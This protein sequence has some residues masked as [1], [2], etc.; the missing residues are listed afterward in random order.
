MLANF[1]THTIFCDGNN[2]PEE[3]V[4]AA[5]EKDFSAIGFS[6]HGY[7][8]FD[9]SY[10]MK[11]TEGYSNEIIRLREKYKNKIQIYLGV[12]EDAFAPIDRSKFD[13]V[14]GSSHYLRHG[15]KYLPIDSSPEEFSECLEAFSGDPI[16]LAE[17][18]Y[19]ELCDYITKRRPDIIGHF[20]LITKYDELGDS[21]FLKDPKYNA[22]AEQAAKI[23]AQSGSIFEVNTGAIT[24]GLRSVAYPAQNVLY[25]LRREDARI[26]LSSD[27]HD[28]STLDAFFDETK[29]YLYDI[30]FRYTYTLWNGEFIKCDI[31]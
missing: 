30:G 27:S 13:Y 28:A 9:T 6:G 23:A 15:C 24:R 8:P 22:V 21:P 11:D 1:H 25:M 4:L 18:Y 14:I 12:E 2:T 26:I 29:H 7:T 3:I 19:G 17:A 20:D 5:I 31:K 10:C 16:R